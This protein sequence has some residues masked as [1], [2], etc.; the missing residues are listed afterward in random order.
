MQDE[1]ERHHQQ[2]PEYKYRPRRYGRDGSTSSA[3]G[4]SNSPLCGKCGGRVINP[5]LSPESLVSPDHQQQQQQ[6][7]AST[8]VAATAT[9][10]RQPD[11]SPSN[12]NTKA[13]LQ[14][15]STADTTSGGTFMIDDQ[16]SPDSKRRR[17]NSSIGNPSESPYP[18]A[19][20]PYSARPSQN[21]PRAYYGLAQLSSYHSP[22]KANMHANNDTAPLRL[23]P[24]QTTA[25][26][27]VVA[28]K[29]A[30]MTPFAAERIDLDTMLRSIPIANKIVVLGKISRPLSPSYRVSSRGPVIAVDGQD[31]R[32]VQSMAEYLQNYL[33]HEGNYNARIFSGPVLPHRRP[34]LPTTPD[35]VGDAM[36]DYLGLVVAW[37]YVSSEVIDFVKEANTRYGGGSPI[38][39]GVS[40]KT[41]FK[42]ERLQIDSSSSPPSTSHEDGPCSTTPTAIVP[43][44]QLTTADAYA[45]S[46][47]L[48]D[49]YSPLDHWQWMA[50]MW[51]TCVGPDVTICI[52][53]CGPEELAQYGGG[54]PVELRLSH[55]TPMLVVRRLTGSRG[56]D[57]EG[58]TL[59]RVGFELVDF[60]TQ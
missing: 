46:I 34:S 19:G 32:S 36:A 38:R 9:P 15:H 55:D 52:H 51:R 17:F 2:F 13:Y 5:P 44:Y 40:P 42:T 41:I 54:T 37:H 12:D 31:A 23:P 4:S 43:R 27:Q 53:E 35:R 18:A 45:R 49:A 24:L 14:E 16:T 47:P 10:P 22:S 56:W 29:S 30:P 11:A 6:G 8:A 26:G 60:L 39:S 3:N 1:K 25:P 21:P 20:I 33:A 58:K 57:I 59:K 50:S 48:N 7:D 28:V